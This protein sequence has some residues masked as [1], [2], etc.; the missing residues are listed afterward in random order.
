MLPRTPPLP[1]V[2]R[3][4]HPVASADASV[5]LSSDLITAHEHPF[6]SK[7]PAPATAFTACSPPPVDH[8]QTVPPSAT[9]SLAPVPVAS[10]TDILSP[11]DVETSTFESRQAVTALSAE[12]RD[13]VSALPF[14]ETRKADRSP[15][16]E[17]QPQRQLLEEQDIER[18]GGEKRN[19]GRNF[20]HVQKRDGA[21]MRHLR[22]V[23]DHAVKFSVKAFSL[24]NLNKSFPSLAREAHE[25]LK[26]AQQQIVEYMQATL[27]NEFERIVEN[28]ELCRKLN[29]ID[30]MVTETKGDP[31]FVRPSP[32]SAVLARVIPVKRAHLAKIRH[33]L[34]E[35]EI[36]N[37]QLSDELY[38]RRQQLAACSEEL[39]TRINDLDTAAQVACQKF[40]IHAMRDQHQDPALSHK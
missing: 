40:P 26:A 39:D 7:L 36:E 35:Y 10:K 29:E 5:E 19:S 9:E 13:T 23:L 11:S 34:K 27:L 14:E 37:T 1:G 30:E 28:R 17:P 8:S 38:I 31:P 21:R 6:L 25:P 15:C 4:L 12:A 3:L 24:P 2:R 16:I 22:R 32:E 33:Q 20:H 18:A